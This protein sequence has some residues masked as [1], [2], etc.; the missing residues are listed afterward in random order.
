MF[1]KFKLGPKI[2][3]ILLFHVTMNKDDS[4]MPTNNNES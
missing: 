2:I 3:L 4:D 1:I